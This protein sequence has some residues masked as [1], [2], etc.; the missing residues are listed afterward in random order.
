[1]YLIL[2]AFIK[3]KSGTG[4]T[5]YTS[6][7]SQD[8]LSSYSEGRSNSNNATTFPFSSLFSFLS[9]QPFYVVAMAPNDGLGRSKSELQF[10]SSELFEKSGGYVL[11]AKESGTNISLRRTKDGRTIL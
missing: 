1:M 4:S 6:Y 8:D 7:Q 3:R 5:L 10:N 9:L 11:D 2:L